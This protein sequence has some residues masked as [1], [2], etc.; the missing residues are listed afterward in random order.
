M[1]NEHKTVA[2]RPVGNSGTSVLAARKHKKAKF[3]SQIVPRFLR[4]EAVGFGG[5]WGFFWSEQDVCRH[6]VVGN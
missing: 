3:E 5:F 1:K 2:K 6:K 4:V